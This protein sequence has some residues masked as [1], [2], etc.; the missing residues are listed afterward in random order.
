MAGFAFLEDGRHQVELT[1][2]TNDP[3]VSLTTKS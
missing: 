2:I 1:N 3:N